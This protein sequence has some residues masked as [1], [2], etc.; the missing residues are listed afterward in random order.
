M[1]I[2]ANHVPSIEP[3]RPGLVEVMETKGNQKFFGWFL[4]PTLS[5]SPF[6]D[7]SGNNVIYSIKWIRNCA[8]QQ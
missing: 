6:I 3:L 2:L 4:L 1:G 8:P 7:I 5:P